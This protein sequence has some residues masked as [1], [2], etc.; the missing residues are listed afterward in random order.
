MS[1]LNFAKIDTLEIDTMIA[2]GRHIRIGVISPE[3]GEKMREGI[4]K[5]SPQSRYYRFFSGADEQPDHVID[6]L[7]S[8]DGV[9]H[10]AWGALDCDQPG[11]PAIAAV[12]A[13]R[14]ETDQPMEFSVV[15]LDDYQGEGVSKLLSAMLF[16]QCLVHGEQTLVA[17]VLEENRRSKTFITHLGGTRQSADGHVVEYRIDVA[18]ALLS[19]RDADVVGKQPVVEAITPYL[20]YFEGSA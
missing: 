18:A 11:A 14:T 12:H 16:A 9:S 5:M 19:M 13:M 2:S 4:S 10:F 17:H 6:R 8:V 15:V 1:K 7:T 3:D 20:S